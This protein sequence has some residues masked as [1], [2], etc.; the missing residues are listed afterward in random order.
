MVGCAFASRSSHI[1]STTNDPYITAQHFT[2]S[3]GL[4][5][6]NVRCIAQDAKGYLWLG[7]LYGLYRF[8]GY[9]Y[10]RIVKEDG[11]DRAL[12]ASNRISNLWIWKNGILIIRFS[13][14]SL[15][16]YDTQNDRFLHA[17]SEQDIRRFYP[18]F[19]WASPAYKSTDN[20]GNKFQVKDGILT[21]R[22]PETLE[23]VR[24][25]I[26][27][28]ELLA[29]SSDF[30]VK[31]VMDKKMNLWISTA[32]AGLYLYNRITQHITH[33]SQKTTPDLIPYDYILDITEDRWGGM[34]VSMQWYGITHLTMAV[35]PYNLIETADKNA[36]RNAREIKAMTR[37]K[38]GDVLTANDFGK[39]MTMDAKGN[40]ASTTL[41]PQGKEYLCFATDLKE[42]VIA[43]TRNSG[44][45]YQG[46]WYENNKRI[47]RIA[48]DRQ[49][50]IWY[51]NI[52]GLVGCIDLNGI[53]H[54]FKPLETLAPEVRAI[55]ADKSG[56]LWLG[57]DKG[58]ISF[59]PDELLRNPKAFVINNN[60]SFGRITALLFD[61][62]GYLWVCTGTGVQIA[63]TKGRNM[64]KAIQKFNELQNVT[65]N[66]IAEDTKGNKW[67]G[68]DNGIIC[69]SPKTQKYMLMVQ[70]SETLLNYCNA[71]C[72]VALK[73]GS[74]AIGTLEGV[75]LT[76]MERLTKNQQKHPLEITDVEQVENTVKIF[77][78]DFNY[79]TDHTTLY[80]YFLEGYDET[81]SSNDKLNY[82]IYRQ[83]PPGDYVFKVKA[84]SAMG[85][86][87]KIQELKIHI[88][89]PW[90]STWWAKLLYL[91][92]ISMAT[93]Y[94]YHKWKRE[95]ELKQAIHD[96]HLLTEYRLKFFTNISHEFRTPLTLIQGS[97]DKM[98]SIGEIPSIYKAS[99]AMLHNSVKRMKRLI[100]QLLEFRK[101]Q[102]NKLALRLEE[103]EM[104][105]M[106]R[107]VFYSFSDI[108]ERRRINM[109]FSTQEKKQVL[110]ADRSYLDKILYNLVSNAF[111]YTPMGGEI[112]VRIKNK[113]LK[114]GTDERDYVYISVIDNGV[115]VAKEKR[116]ELFK[117]YSRTQVM[118]DSIGIGLNL[119]AE[120]VRTHHGNI[121]YE[122]NPGGGSIFS[123][124]LPLGKDVYQPEDFL[125]KTALALQQEHENRI[126]L[127][128]EKETAAEPFNH[129]TILVV[130]DDKDILD[131]LQQELGIYFHVEVAMDGE[132]AIEILEDHLPA[133]VISDIV[134]PRKGGLA[135]LKHIRSSSYSYLPVILLTAQDSVIQEEKSY[136]YGA[137]AYIAKPFSMKVL[138]A[139]CV[140]ILKRQSTQAPTEKPKEKTP[141]ILTSDTEQKFLRQ[142]ER[143]VDSKLSD[144]TLS[145]DLMAEALGYGRTAFYKK[146]NAL[147]GL[148][149]KEYIRKRRLQHAAEMLKNDRITVSEVAYQCGFSSSQ[150]FASTFRA[151]FGV[152]PTEF[153]KHS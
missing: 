131:Y 116:D 14:Q 44:L 144:T 61:K 13:N 81:W 12:M 30:K 24:I 101:M 16:A 67:I 40:L 70:D 118:G 64:I 71:N 108:A 36:L 93:A 84:L 92:I 28:Q 127:K 72:L 142:L 62:S 39:V 26:I 114:S 7:T 140:N 8:D 56:N 120:L 129:T 29:I 17:G 106:V 79:T 63:Q 97:M 91:A 112:M 75:L 55:V 137:D 37:L 87:S 22:D 145:V 143:Y 107:E 96:E 41:V 123:F 153:Q 58:L 130:E 69:Y 6:N 122:E 51:A 135:L 113:T 32:G 136:R 33:L 149:P 128:T 146:V 9:S 43:G 48:T 126:W 23:E 103:I 46:K 139:Q 109:L 132:E 148:S 45:Y 105:E 152:T 66:S 57:T 110:Y 80:K 3:T 138:V 21:W 27:P 77:F 15:A 117:R 102:N 90:Y 49:G 4:P 88:P 65:V 74:V 100:D 150:Y 54:T 18:D 34:W 76:D 82:A 68:T 133:L 78:S 10:K 2:T 124:S 1:S 95:Q 52:N 31:V 83:L 50:R 125:D 147:T 59:S 94:I 121:T 35:K 104:V 134:M 141:E 5:N 86:E 111:K 99:F 20:H 98:M 73:Q 11:G 42:N 89:C 119:T 53:T 85:G 151:Y 25:R 19:R 115:G 47:D 38:N 60:Q